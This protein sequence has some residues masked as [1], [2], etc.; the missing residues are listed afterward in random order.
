M[1]RLA[2]GLLSLLGVPCLALAQIQPDDAVIGHSNSSAAVTLEVVR[3]AAVVP[4]FWATQN[5]VQYVQFDNTFGLSVGSGNLIGVN[6]GTA[7]AGGSLHNF[8]TQGAAYLAG[9]TQVN[10]L[11]TPGVQLD[12]LSF[13]FNNSRLAVTE[14]Q[15][16]VVAAYDYS[17]GVT[18]GQGAGASVNA[19]SRIA[20][21][22]VSFGGNA[23]TAGDTE[24]TTWLGNDSLVVAT[25]SGTGATLT[26]FQ[27]IGGVVAGSVV[28]NFTLQA[29]ANTFWGLEYNPDVSDFLFVSASAFTGG[30]TFNSLWVLDAATFAILDV[31]NQDS[32]T[33]AGLATAREIGLDSLGRLV[34]AGFGGTLSR[35]TIDGT[36]NVTNYEQNF[37]DSATNSSFPGL[38]VSIV[39]EPTTILLGGLGLG[40]VVLGVRRHRTRRQQRRN[41]ASL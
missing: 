21:D 15:N 22:P 36:G 8:A 16:N 11:T 20:L 37:F 39:P 18:P 26:R 25:R 27:N 9:T 4:D 2:Y 28:Q 38:A 33:L 31:V 19:A 5:F 10:I 34:V 7:A 40:S 13:A 30:V 41:K 35:F 6:R 1:N 32:G 12:G 24:G 29:D 17:A 3:S 14:V 23:L